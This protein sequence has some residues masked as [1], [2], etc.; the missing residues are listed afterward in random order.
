MSWTKKN[1]HPGQ[2]RLHLAGSRRHGAGRRHASKRRISLGL[3]QCPWPTRGRA[4]LERIPAARVEGEVE[5]H[6]VRS[7]RG[8]ARR[9]RRHGAPVRPRLERAGRR[10]HPATSRRATMVKAKVLDVDVEKERIS[11]GIKQ[12]G[13][14]SAGPATAS[15][16][17]QTVTVTV[18]EITSG[19]IEVKF[20]DDD[21]PATAFIRKSD[22][23]RDRADQRPERFAVGD[24]VDALVTAVDKRH[25]P[26]LGVDQG[27]GDEG[28]EGSRRAVRVAGFR[29]FAGRHPGRSSEGK[30]PSTS[31]ATKSDGGRG[32]PGRRFR[33]R[34][35]PE[36]VRGARP[37]VTPICSVRL[38]FGP[39]WAPLAGLARRC[40]ALWPTTP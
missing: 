17:G 5:H 1:V 7:V 27:A 24:R 35:G 39:L 9:H 20:G 29:R 30:G 34:G 12:L 37:V 25:A 6:R 22:L 4:F 38:D 23:S 3:K 15:A 40:S 26:H 10:S 32:F 33:F 8:P 31:I 18:T 16:S 19:G 13:Q 21:A 28:R 36:R 2:D 11:L 14:R